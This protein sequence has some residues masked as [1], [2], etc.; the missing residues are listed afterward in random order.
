MKLLLAQFKKL[1]EKIDN[2]GNEIR[3]LSLNLSAL[4]HLTEHTTMES[5]QYKSKSKSPEECIEY[6]IQE[7]QSEGFPIP[8]KKILE[9]LL[10]IL[11]YMIA[12]DIPLPVISWI[13]DDQYYQISWATKNYRSIFSF[14][15]DEEIRFLT[16]NK[17]NQGTRQ[18]SDEIQ[19]KGKSLGKSIP[20]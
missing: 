16:D 8:E 11:Q 14:T 5:I 3:Q 1:E 18:Y 9:D 10:T 17:G 2:Q 20:L 13:S 15:W 6:L 7:L 19:V 12:D 4:L